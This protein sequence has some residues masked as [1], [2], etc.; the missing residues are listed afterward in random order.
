M[1]EAD[2]H[3]C[4]ETL[5][6]ILEARAAWRDLALQLLSHCEPMRGPKEWQEALAAFALRAET[7]RRKEEGC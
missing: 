5:T 2:L 3:Q 4:T 1:T 6:R 7:I